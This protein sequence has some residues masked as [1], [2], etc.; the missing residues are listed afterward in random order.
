[1]ALGGARFAGPPQPNNRASEPQPSLDIG[2][3][4]MQPLREPLDHAAD[5]RV[6]LV[7]GL[8][9]RRRDLLLARTGGRGCPLDTGKRVAHEVDPRRVPRSA[10]DHRTPGRGRPR[11]LAVRPAGTPDEPARPPGVARAP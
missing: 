2:A 7:G 11:A 1:R 8:A 5:H 3:A 9:R 6:A 10:L 4:A